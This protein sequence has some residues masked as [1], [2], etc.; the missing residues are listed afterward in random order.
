M[1][2][3]VIIGLAIILSTQ[4]FG[5]TDILYTISGDVLSGE[6][7][8]M[9]QSV[10]TFDTKYADD[11][12]KIEWSEVT[13]VK[14]TGLQ[15]IFTDDG[16]RYIGRLEP[17][18]GTARLIRVITETEEITMTLEDIVEIA[19]LEKNF[20]ERIVISLDAGYSFTKANNEQRLSIDGSI[21][22]QARKWSSETNFSKTGTYQDAVD[23]TSRTDGESNLNYLLIGKSYA[24]L[25]IEFLRNS[26]QL[27][28]LRSTAKI[29][30]GYYIVRTN[31]L[32]FG[33]GAGLARSKE[34][35]GG[36]EP[37]SENSF[38]GLGVITLNAYDVGDISTSL[39][40]S[41]YPSFT[42][43]GRQRFDADLSFKYD[44]P[45]DFYIKFSYTHNFDSKPLIK[46]ENENQNNYIN[47]SSFYDGSGFKRMGWSTSS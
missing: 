41:Y 20:A 45:L 23:A 34:N 42:N 46:K 13:G 33:G 3:F 7:K 22:Y 24:F 8:S 44:L 18:L 37:S 2:R 47:C 40:L 29:G 30:L 5:Q 15:L 6:M 10:L 31:H 12:F 1:K 16:G 43:K 17:L 4:L 28:D 19:A 32:Y 21:K 25:G 36:D 35:Y 26:E 27:L 9:R 38:E 11:E 39:N 14:A